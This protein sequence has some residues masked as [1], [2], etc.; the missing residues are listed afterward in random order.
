MLY[1]SSKPLKK[2]GVFLELGD[3]VVFKLSNGAVISYRVYASFLQNDSSINDSIFVN[4]NIDKHEIARKYYFKKPVVTPGEAWPYSYSNDYAS[5]TN[6]VIALFEMIEG[7][8]KLFEPTKV[9]LSKKGLQ[10]L[11]PLVCE[12]WKLRIKASLIESLLEDDVT[13][14][15]SELEA[16]YTDADRTQKEALDKYLGI[17]EIFKSKQ[18]SAS[19]LQIGE[20]LEIAYPLQYKGQRLLRTYSG[21]VSLDD[22]SS[23]WGVKDP[24]IRGKKLLK[25]TRILVEVK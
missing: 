19:D 3:N 25:H 1:T 9:K 24:K 4:L 13:V 10:S 17:S 7:T 12:G 20:I 22:A 5:L 2:A 14:N 6:L 15:I 23:T 21:F 18:D 11:Y 16:A 8:V